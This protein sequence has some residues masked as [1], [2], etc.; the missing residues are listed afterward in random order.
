MLV[1]RAVLLASISAQL[2][3]CL[4]PRKVAMRLLPP[5]NVPQR[6]TCFSLSLP[7]RDVVNAATANRLIERY[8]Q[9]FGEFQIPVIWG[10]DDLTAHDTIYHLQAS[11]LP[12]EFAL[13]CD[14]DWTSS[15]TSSENVRRRL[16]RHLSTA[17]TA[18][19]DI[20]TL[21]LRGRMRFDRWD[22]FVRGGIRMVVSDRVAPADGREKHPIKTLRFGL[23]EMQAS[24]V[25]ADEGGRRSGL[26]M[27]RQIDRA[28]TGGGLCHVVLGELLSADRQSLRPLERLL[29]HV[30]RRRDEGQLQVQTI[31]Q[32][33]VQLPSRRSSRCAQSILRS[34][35]SISRAA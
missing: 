12:H 23:W 24:L 7:S 32:I 6:V 11:Q 18:G 3:T 35:S 13:C 10:L 4:L 2:S 30:A 21:M 28:M 9:L 31:S 17:R 25:L 8:V 14:A 19:L 5:S 34:K 22:A 20:A 15:T 29:Q 27:R 16:Q 1:H 26:A 33:V